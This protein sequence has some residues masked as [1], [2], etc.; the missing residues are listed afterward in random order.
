MTPTTEQIMNKAVQKIKRSIKHQRPR[1]KTEAERRREL[2]IGR[3]FFSKARRA[4]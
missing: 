3:L 2:Q 1:V 4:A